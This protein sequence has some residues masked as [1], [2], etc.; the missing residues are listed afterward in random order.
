MDF[1]QAVRDAAPGRAV[2]IRYWRG[3]EE[4]EFVLRTSRAPLATA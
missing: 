3:S 4:G 2:A 1:F